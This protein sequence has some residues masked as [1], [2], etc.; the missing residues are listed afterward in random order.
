M[1]DTYSYEEAIYLISSLMRDPGSW[2][3]ASKMGMEYPQSR[4]LQALKDIWNL[5]AAVNTDRKKG[6]APKYPEPYKVED[7]KDTAKIG[8]RS[9]PVKRALEIF[10]MV[11]PARGETKRKLSLEKGK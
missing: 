10:K 4:I 2:T 7:K 9:V 3:Y 1:G 8:T 6:K 11:N 5:L